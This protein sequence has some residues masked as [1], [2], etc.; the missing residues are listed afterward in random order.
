MGVMLSRVV[1]WALNALGFWWFPTKD[2]S[3]VEGRQLLF[4]GKEQEKA[5]GPEPFMINV[6]WYFGKAS[7]HA[8][9]YFEFAGEDDY[10]I[11]VAIPRLFGI[12]LTLPRVPKLRFWNAKEQLPT[13]PGS[14]WRRYRW[15]DSRYIGIFYHHGSVWISLLSDRM[16]G[17]YYKHTW[18]NR[19]RD[20]HFNFEDAIYGRSRCNH[21]ELTEPTPIKVSMPE[22]TYDAVIW[23]GRRTWKW[24]RFR[25]PK[26]KD[27]TEIEVE[28]P[29]RFAGKGENGWDMDDD[30]IFATSFDGHLTADEAAGQYRARVM[31]YRKKYGE[32]SEAAA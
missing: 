32:P 9:V 12:Y 4:L 28:N 23:H 16:N 26:I 19:F 10:Q 6:E 31:E 22:G 17:D 8:H 29:P 25:K 7:N 15:S 11:S 24:A 18:F 27:Y 2:N 20:L 21:E 5:G 13:K 3:I 1:T 14:K 30:S